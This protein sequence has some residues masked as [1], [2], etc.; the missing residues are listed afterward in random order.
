M[1]NNR[2]TVEDGLREAKILSDK[3]SLRTAEQD[4]HSQAISSSEANVV[5]LGHTV[6]Q[7]KARGVGTIAFHRDI[8]L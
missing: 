5:C 2:M 8:R 3:E 4:P 7:S 6:G 1:A